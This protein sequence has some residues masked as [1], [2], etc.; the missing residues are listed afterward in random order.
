MTSLL[1]EQPLTEAATAD[2][3]ARENVLLR[4]RNAQLEA[5]LAAIREGDTDALIISGEGGDRLLPLGRA[6]D[7][8]RL[9]VEEMGNGAITL[10]P[11]GVI[12][13]ANR[14]FAEMV[15][16]PL[17][18]VIGS[19]VV[20]CFAAEERHAVLALLR[21]AP[22]SK[23]SAEV[24]LLTEAGFRVPALLSVRRLALDGMPDAICMMVT[25]L[26]VQKRGESAIETGRTLLQMVATLRQAAVQAKAAGLAKREYV[27][28]V[29][30]G[31]RKPLNAVIG[32]S[33]LLSQTPLGPEQV[34]I[35]DKI[36]LASKS[37][38][39]IINNVLDLA[40]IEAADLVVERVGSYLEGDLGDRAG[41]A[42]ARTD[43]GVMLR[44]RDL[45]LPPL[46]VAVDVPTAGR[47]ASSQARAKVVADEVVERL[48]R[49]FDS[50]DP[51][52]GHA[53]VASMFERSR[54]LSSRSYP[55]L[56]RP[57]AVVR[58]GMDLGSLKL[59]IARQSDDVAAAGAGL[60]HTTFVGL[61]ADLLGDVLVQH[62]LGPSAT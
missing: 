36:K 5:S 40:S 4:Q 2:N 56:C 41:M 57:M 11:K 42:G 3:I 29:G 50:L 14:G 31:I 46:D 35:L 13:Y 16:R 24:D 12:A 62:L 37:L 51:V 39:M 38:L 33:Y 45:P 19:R 9:L 61:I 58:N 21:D 28:D 27:A 47:S 55:W 54:L 49:V 15:G 25:D 17:Q 60:L 32:Q 30:H 48:Q 18:Q 22:V 34:E 44:V 6:D 53:A 26:T 20:D 7:T 23:R 1:E 52:I 43:E 10:T 59:L 8:Y